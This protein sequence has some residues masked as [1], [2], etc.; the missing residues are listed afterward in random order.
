MNYTKTIRNYC[1]N[2][3][4]KAFDVSYEYKN[5]YYMMQYKTFCKI[6]N[7]L[8]DEG[9]ITTYSK[10]IYL[11]NSDWVKEDPVL[12]FYAN[13]ETGMVIGYQMYHDLGIIKYT[14][15][16]VEILTNA[17]QTTTKNVGDGY[18]LILFK[19]FFDKFVK[20]LIVALEII[21]N[22]RNIVDLDWFKMN[23]TLIMH[24]QYYK[25][26]AFENILN[27]RSYSLS[28]IYTLEEYLKDLQIENKVLEIA[29]E[30]FKNTI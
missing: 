3:P 2:N 5:H 27:N 21:E 12:S 22:S 24:L 15:G 23:K 25:D 1:L 26:Y 30:Y 11:I 20:K 8:E 13:D 28:T 14:E 29:K 16:P 7:R 6:L 18:K 19:G 17:M 10:G 9:I 4:G